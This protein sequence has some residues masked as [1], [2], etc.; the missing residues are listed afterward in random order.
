MEVKVPAVIAIAI[1]AFISFAYAIP[2]TLSTD[3]HPIVGR[4]AIDRSYCSA[5]QW[6]HLLL[7]LANCR[8]RSRVA[9]DAALDRPDKLHEN[10]KYV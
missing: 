6:T 3:H 8:I 2:A 1:A 9:A 5:D 10:F 4:T 7:A